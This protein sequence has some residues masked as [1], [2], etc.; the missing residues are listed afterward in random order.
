MSGMF[1]FPRLNSRLSARQQQHNQLIS[2]LD[3]EFDL[4][5]E[6][7]RQLQAKEEAPPSDTAAVSNSNQQTARSDTD[8]LQVAHLV[9]LA[10]KLEIDPDDISL[11]VLAWKLQC[12]VPFSV[13][14]VEWCQGLAALGVD[15][16]TG[17]KSIIPALQ[18]QTQ[19]EKNLKE[20]YFWIFMWLRDS[21][22]AKFLQVDTALTMW[23]IL[24]GPQTGHTF[25]ALDEWL[26]F[27]STQK[28]GKGVT[29]DV[30]RQTFDFASVD[31]YTDISPTNP[32]GYDEAGSW[33]SV[34][35]EF[36]SWARK[37][38]VQTKIAPL[39]IKEGDCKAQKEKESYICGGDS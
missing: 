39:G 12:V 26:E 30:W 4:I 31:I 16:I 33:P 11:Y 29:K 35:D 3:K 6:T 20:F 8:I 7:V 36:V 18:A 1:N 17:L 5:R 38:K 22:V 37:K 10:E 13:Q 9:H 34:M 23:P 24:F 32:M 28:A 2:Q 27:W 25:A 19:N 15:S 14:R 21:E